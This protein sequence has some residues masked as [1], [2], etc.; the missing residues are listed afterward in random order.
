MGKRPLCG[1]DNT[2]ESFDA[3]NG[4]REFEFTALSVVSGLRTG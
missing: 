1:T 3:E 4:R 2:F